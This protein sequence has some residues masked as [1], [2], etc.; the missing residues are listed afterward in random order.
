MELDDL[1]AAVRATARVFDN[2]EVAWPRQHA[3]AAIQ[4]LGESGSLILGLD[5]RRDEGRGVREEPW[6][7]IWPAERTRAECRRT[8][9]QALYD[10]HCG[11]SSTWLE[12]F[13]WVL[14]T[15]EPLG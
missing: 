6:S 8:V 4:A 7:S 13:P 10:L 1:P 12:T 5:F 11:L 2:G 15:W 3:A 14:V 9:D